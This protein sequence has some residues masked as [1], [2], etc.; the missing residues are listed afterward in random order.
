MKRLH[1]YIE[2]SNKSQLYIYIYKTNWAF[3]HVSHPNNNHVLIQILF[4]EIQLK[5]QVLNYQLLM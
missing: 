3:I 1:Y 5:L 2:I 4:A